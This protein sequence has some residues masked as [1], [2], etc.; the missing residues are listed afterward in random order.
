MRGTKFRLVRVPVRTV[1]VLVALV[2]PRPAAA[3]DPFEIQVYDGTANAPGVPGLELHVNDVAAGLTTAPSPELAQNHQAHFTLEPSLGITPFWEIG[4]YV[5]TALLPDG[6]FDFAGLK[7]RSKFVT[8]P[9][10]RPNLRLG[11]N[12]E[13]SWLPAAFEA[14]RW[15]GEIRNIVAWENARWLFAVN[16]IIEVSFNG[17]APS[18]APAATAVFKVLGLASVGFEYYGDVSD[19][20]HYLF[21]VVNFDT[22]RIEVNVGVGEGLTH[23]SNALVAKMILGYRL[24]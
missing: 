22:T 5:Q 7:L 21:Q 10:W 6:A 23:S 18:F 15:G 24:E 19:R 20:A 9:G 3:V 14:A 13:V 12:L 1:A 4:A 16:P 17:D 8:R 2:A 11:C